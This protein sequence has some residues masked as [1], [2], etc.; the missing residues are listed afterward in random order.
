[1]ETFS[2]YSVRQSEAIEN[3]EN[4]EIGTQRTWIMNALRLLDILCFWALLFEWNGHSGLIE[5]VI[6]INYMLSVM[7]GRTNGANSQTLSYPRV[8][9]KKPSK[10]NVKSRKRTERIR[11]WKMA[12]VILIGIGLSMKLS[13][14]KCK[15]GNIDSNKKLMRLETSILIRN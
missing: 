1:M 12:C 15:N 14:M 11:Q 5:A 3:A 4:A 10:A 13:C 6:M 2:P 8:F 7:H 9:H